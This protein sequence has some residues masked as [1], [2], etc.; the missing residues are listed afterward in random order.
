MEYN[1][2][3]KREKGDLVYYFY[4]TF[5]QSGFFNPP[6]KENKTID[7]IKCFLSSKF[8]GFFIYIYLTHRMIKSFLVSPFY[9]VEPEKR[10]SQAQDCVQYYSFLSSS[11]WQ[12]DKRNCALQAKNTLCIILYFDEATISVFN[13][14]SL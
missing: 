3:R 13:H 9:T 11:S 12:P 5:F 6:K 2:H 14:C 4:T 10:I 7:S 1:E 8:G